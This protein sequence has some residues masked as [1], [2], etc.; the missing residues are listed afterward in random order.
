MKIYNCG[1]AVGLDV[2]G[3]VGLDVGGAVGGLVI[4]TDERTP[5]RPAVLQH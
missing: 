4:S 2:G 1:D 3:A 5:L